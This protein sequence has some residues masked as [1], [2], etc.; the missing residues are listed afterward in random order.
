[1]AERRAKELC[2]N[3]DESYLKGHEC[4]R[5]FWIEVPDEENGPEEGSVNDPTI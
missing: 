5:L 2:Y 4:K 1:M 3:C